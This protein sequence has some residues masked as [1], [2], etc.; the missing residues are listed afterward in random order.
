MSLV[1]NAEEYVLAAI[2]ALKSDKILNF[3]PFGLKSALLFERTPSLEFDTN[4]PSGPPFV[5]HEAL[6]KLI[7]EH[8]DAAVLIDKP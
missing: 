8:S 4:N 5:R 1:K 6:E 3:N 7:L 2:E